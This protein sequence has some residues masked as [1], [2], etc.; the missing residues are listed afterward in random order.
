MRKQAT[1][2]ELSEL[3]GV[4]EKTIAQ[5]AQHGIMAKLAHGKYDL[6]ESL[7][8]WTAYQKTI[9]R[10]CN[11]PLDVWWIQRDRDWSEAHPLPSYNPAN[12]VLVDISELGTV[13]LD[14]SGRVIGK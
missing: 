12:V 9:H 14:A 2:A 4:T 7:R 5:W 10:G 6:G 1:T 11:N 8:N 13:E 3:L